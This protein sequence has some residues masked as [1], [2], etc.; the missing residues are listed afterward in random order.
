MDFLPPFFL[1]YFLTPP[2]PISPL[3]SHRL[4]F[5]ADLPQS[6]LPLGSSVET[7]AGEMI[8]PRGRDDIC[9]LPFGIMDR[10]GSHLV[11]GELCKIE[12]TRAQ[13]L[14]AIGPASPFLDATAQHRQNRRVHQLRKQMLGNARQANKR[15]WVWV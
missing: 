8:F 14:K 7:A 4:G 1:L 15:E 13:P 3:R 12:G 6:P 5:E 9:S 2:P 10:G 11:G